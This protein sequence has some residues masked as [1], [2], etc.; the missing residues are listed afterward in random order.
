MCPN[1]MVLEDFKAKKEV[2]FTRSGLVNQE[3]TLN[4]ANAKI[5]D[6]GTLAP[7]R[8]ASWWST[9][10]R[11]SRVTSPPSGARAR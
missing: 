11:T 7:Q 6:I 8:F 5:A 4:A 2:R 10:T 9:S 3:D 1:G